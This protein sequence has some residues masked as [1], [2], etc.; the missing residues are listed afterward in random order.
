MPAPYAFNGRAGTRLALLRIGTGGR[1]ASHLGTWSDR[2]LWVLV[3]PRSA[4]AGRA[5][6]AR[7]LIARSTASGCYGA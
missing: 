3:N 1:V 4:P 5:V 7:L 6:S 2:L